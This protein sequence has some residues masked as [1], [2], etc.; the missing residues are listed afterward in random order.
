M[1]SDNSPL[2]HP[3]IYSVGAL[4][5]VDPEHRTGRPPSTTTTTLVRSNTSLSLSLSSSSSSSPDAAELAQQKFDTARSLM[6]F[7]DGNWEGR[8][9][10][11]AVTS[12]VAE[13]MHRKNTLDRYEI[14]TSTSLD[15]TNGVCVTETLSYHTNDDNDNND[16]KFLHSR[17]LSL[18]ST[19]TDVDFVDGSYS[20]DTSIMDLP[21]ALIGTEAIVKF[22]VEHCL[23]ISDNERVKMYALYGMDDYLINVLYYCKGG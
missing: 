12:D 3:S 16:D 4:V 2:L 6:D 18:G 9:I 11:F 23:A 22:G 7:H 21:S 8:A 14:T 19:S 5:R 1:A 17:T 20:L 13:G 10:S 15:K